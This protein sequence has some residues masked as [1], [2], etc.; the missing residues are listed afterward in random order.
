[1]EFPDHGRLGHGEGPCRD[2][3]DLDLMR[4]EKRDV[5][6][7]NRSAPVHI[8]IARTDEIDR[9]RSIGIEAD[10]RYLQSRHPEFCD[11]TSIPPAVA[12]KA[13]SEGRLWVSVCDQVPVGWVYVSRLDNEYCVGQISVITAY[14]RRGIGT[15]LLHQA[16]ANARQRGEK[17]IIVAT[18]LDVP[19]NGPWYAREGYV[20][21]QTSEWSIMMLAEARRQAANGL[22]WT[23]RAFMRL[24]IGGG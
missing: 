20:V 19:W 21:L 3:L 13:I 5:L 11:G 6:L 17:S 23:D 10:R 15:G 18:Q 16:H 2:H 8:R 12:E 7:D 9:L 4:I 1:M 24:L 14:G 22:D